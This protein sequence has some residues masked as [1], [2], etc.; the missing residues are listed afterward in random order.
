VIVGAPH[1]ERVSAFETEHDSILVVHTYGV[2]P[3]H[4]TTERVQPVAG[5]NLQILE[6]RYGVDLIEFATHVR[7]ELTRNPPSRL[8]VDAVPDV[9]RGVIR[10]RPNHSL[11]L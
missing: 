8:A 2:Q 5:R 9:P 4:V 6:A 7:P 11:A 10:Q 1:V 3:S